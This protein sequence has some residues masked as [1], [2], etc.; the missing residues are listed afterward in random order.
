MYRDGRRWPGWPKMIFVYPLEALAVY[1][2]YGFLKLLPIDWASN[3]G[4]WLGRNLGPK[5]G[6]SRKAER[7][8]IR[9]MP[10][11]SPKERQR[12]M[13]GMWDNLGRVIG[14]Y[15]HLAAIWRQ[16]DKRI[17]CVGFEHLVQLRD[18]DQPGIMIGGHLGN[19]EL[20]QIGAQTQGLELGLIYRRPNNPLVIP[21]MRHMRRS[22][23]GH[24]FAKGADGG[25][26]ALSF[27]AKGGHLGLL[28]DQKLND[29]VEV[30]FFGIPAMTAP[31][32]ARFALRYQCPVVPMRTERLAGC[33]FRISVLP[34]VPVRDSGDRDADILFLLGQLNDLIEA[35]VRERPE[36]WLWLH[37]RWTKEEANQSST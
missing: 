26:Q 11:L 33:R 34:P 9:A 27:L 32:T 25:K 28:I 2:L 23:T 31:A 21:L 36:Q 17:E 30:P 15:P 4:G 14:E 20:A 18:D 5:L 29:G 24:L 3:L 12:I 13:H 7:N 22:A 35:W 8:L 19:W 10:E 16:Q 37:Q 1:L 6:A